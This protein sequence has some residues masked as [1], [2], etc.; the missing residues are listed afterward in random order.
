M[1][2]GVAC[3]IIRKLKRWTTENKNRGD[4]MEQSVDGAAVHPWPSSR[5]AWATV[6]VLLA[7]Y[8]VAFV[9]RQI[10]TLLVEP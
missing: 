2:V 4:G 9:D 8:A 1:P 6:L 7:A 5:R 3:T 10:L